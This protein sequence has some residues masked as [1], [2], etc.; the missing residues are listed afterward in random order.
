MFKTPFSGILI[1]LWIVNASFIGT[2][3]E[4]GPN[5]DCDQLSRYTFSWQFNTGCKLVPRGGVTKGPD[6]TVRKTPTKGWLMLQQEHTS[7]KEKD[8]LAILAMAGPYRVSFDFLEVMGF[9]SEFTPCLLYTSPS[10]RD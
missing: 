5:D 2:A 9:S 4:D 7:K 1:L 3:R 10:P 6:V 8:R